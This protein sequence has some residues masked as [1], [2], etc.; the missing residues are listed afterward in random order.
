MIIKVK[1]KSYD[2]LSSAVTTQVKQSGIATT[3]IHQDMRLKRI[4]QQ[5]DGPLIIHP[6]I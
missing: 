3:S 6:F 4:I 1:K 5:R 2:D